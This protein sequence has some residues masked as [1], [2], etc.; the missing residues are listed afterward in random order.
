V[1][2]ADLRRLQRTVSLVWRSAPGATLAASALLF[3]Q[4]VLPLV[5]LYLFKLIVDAV[6]D[7]AG[8]ERVLILIG[9]AGVVAVAGALSRAAAAYAGEA[10]ALHV[11]DFMM[12]RLQEKSVAVDYEYYED[13]RY[14]NTLHRA[15]LEAPHRPT[16]LLGNLTQVAQNAVTSMG[17]VVLIATVHLVLALVVV[18]AVLPAFFFRVRHA[19]KLHAWQREQSAT[20]RKAQY[21]GWLTGNAL[22]AKEVRLFDL[23][24][25]L[26]DRFRSLRADLR[27]GRLGL[28]RARN[29]ADAATQ[30]GAAVVVLGSYAFIA[31]L[32]LEGTL[33]VG[34]LVLFFGAV[35][36]GQGSLQA[37]FGG[38]AA[39]YEDS[40]FLSNVDEFFDLEPQ[41]TAPKRPRRVPRLIREGLVCEGVRFQYPSSPGPV[42]RDVDLELRPGEVVALVGPNGSG[43]STLVKLLCR[44][45]DPLDGRITLDGI[46][47]REMDP[48]E[49]RSRI[50]PVFQDYARFHLTAGENIWFGDVARPPAPAPARP[51]GAAGRGGRGGAATPPRLRHDAGKTVSG[52]RG[53]EHRG[54][55]ED[56]P[57][58]GL[59]G[60]PTHPARGRAHERAGRHRRGR[61][62]P[63]S[64][65]AGAEPGG[66]GREPPPLD[67]TPGR[68]DLLHGA[69]KGCGVGHARRAHGAGRPIRPAL[70]RP[71]PALHGIPVGCA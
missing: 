3:V 33:S 52:G 49:L 19:R 21:L 30:I 71:V 14:Y 37:L 51:A 6:V 11:T 13:P 50:A 1:T 44:L 46:D 42:L 10:Q 20:E 70:R 41:V 65:R 48:R 26:R 39:L 38:L 69:G 25:V 18:A 67:R 22:Y 59:P 43:K 58:P 60:R 28:A 55:A 45:Y 57:G 32:T 35:Q 5:G 29:S 17:I 16:R 9:L 40:L 12:E 8:L 36:R 4:A 68:P 64:P 24:G 23:G 56:R 53:A 47:L 31:W 7:A 15:Q 34:D 62:D 54:M 61:G 66:P 2:R 63:H 27:Q